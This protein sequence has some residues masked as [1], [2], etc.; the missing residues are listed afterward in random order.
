MTLDESESVDDDVLSALKQDG[1]AGAPRGARSRVLARLGV[2]VAASVAAGAHATAASASV[3]KAASTSAAPIA[4]G[5]LGLGLVKALVAHPVVG[6][7]ATLALGSGVGIGA[8]RAFE[9]S[10]ASAPAAATVN[11]VPMAAP[12]PA[13]APEPVS[14]RPVAPPGEPVAAERPSDPPEPRR[15][16]Q[17]VSHAPETALAAAPDLPSEASPARLAEQQV[18]LDQARA[19]LRRGDGAGALAVGLEHEKRYPVTK[20][21]EERE[22][23]EI[24]ARVMLGRLDEA[25]AQSARFATRFPTSLFLPSIQS[26]L[27]PHDATG[28]V[29][30]PK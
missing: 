14:A 5:A 25:R 18:L 17:G 21:A 8:Y 24:L 1:R 23:I 15:A 9:P 13:R 16:P 29:E 6:V 26:S 27:A 11:P 2:G 3:G 22:A 19:A 20:F 7:I 4:T 28:E 12:K 10:R 30:A